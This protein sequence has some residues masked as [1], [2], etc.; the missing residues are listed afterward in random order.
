M[1]RTVVVIGVGNELRGDD[2]AGLEAARRVRESELPPSVTVRLHEGEAVG[3][4]E[5]WDGADAAVLVD[6]VRSG[7]PPGTIHR[8]DAS[9]GPLPSPIRRS[10]S[11]TIGIAEAIELS[12]ALGTLPPGILVYGVEGRQFEAGTGLS[13]EVGEALDRLVRELRAEAMRVSTG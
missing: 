11:H 4:L 3:L 2:G 1:P 7:A 6:T 9:H 12:R 10:S 8:L 5:L 13:D